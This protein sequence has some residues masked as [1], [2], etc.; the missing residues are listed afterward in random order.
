MMLRKTYTPLFAGLKF[1]MLLAPATAILF[2]MIPLARKSIGIVLL[3]GFAAGTCSL[4]LLFGDRLWLHHAA[5]ILLILYLGLALALEY[6]A[7]T[8]SLAGWAN[9]ALAL[10]FLILGLGNAIDRQRVMLDLERTGGVGL[11]SDAI[12]RFAEDS[13]SDPEPTFAFFPDWGV[14]MPFEM[15]TGGQIPLLTD[16]SP[17][18]A[19]RKLCEG[20]DALLAIIN[21]KGVDRLAPWID[22]VGWGSPEIVVYRQRDNVPV[23]TSV[24]WR[25]SAPTHP[26]CVS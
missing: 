4:F 6:I 16:F 22:A 7:K 2:M 26:V 23:L 8:T 1:L 25:A 15:V 20:Q 24:R 11:A 3:F 12:E 5:M 10:P 21:D 13:R 19:L 14:F 9:W 17:E 18:A